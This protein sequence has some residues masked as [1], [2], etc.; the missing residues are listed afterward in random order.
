[1]LMSEIDAG[2]KQKQKTNLSTNQINSE[3]FLSNQSISSG[4]MYEHGTF[5]RATRD[6]KSKNKIFSESSLGK[7]NL[8]A[9]F[10]ESN[11]SYSAANDYVERGD[12]CFKVYSIKILD[13]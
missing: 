4:R 6:K 13:N 8:N 3:S 5:N 12:Y 9:Q 1:M 11:Q 7:K 10:E 2:H